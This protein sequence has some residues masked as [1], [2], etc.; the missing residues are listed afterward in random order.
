MIN[1]PELPDCGVYLFWPEEGT[2]WIHP[3]DLSIVEGWIPSTRVFRRHSYDG[4]YYR[5]Q[6]GVD[7]LRVKPTLW[8]KVADEGFWV[9]DQ[10]EVR[11][12]LMDREPCIA[13]ISEMTFDRVTSRILYQLIHREMPLPNT[14]TSDDLIQ[15]SSRPQLKEHEREIVLNPKQMLG[16]DEP[17]YK[18]ESTDEDK[19]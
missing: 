5:L 7:V 18:L 19:V 4:V 13:T 15:L 11:G 14:Y 12:L 6:Y 3:D 8:L 1:W 2:D 17:G 9:G 16:K 10:V